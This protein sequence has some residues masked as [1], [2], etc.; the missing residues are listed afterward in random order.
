MEL[1]LSILLAM[2]LGFES[3]KNKRDKLDAGFCNAYSFNAGN[4]SRIRKDEIINPIRIYNQAFLVIL[5][6]PK[7]TK[8]KN[9]IN[10]AALDPDLSTKN[11]VRL[12][13]KTKKGSLYFDFLSGRVCKTIANK[14]TKAFAKEFLSPNDPVIS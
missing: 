1:A 4:E 11:M 8:S 7:I 2:D 13:I 10:N 3:E 9:T 14:K 12:I 5:L 6:N